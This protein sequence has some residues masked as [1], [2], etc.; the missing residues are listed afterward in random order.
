MTLAAKKLFAPRSE[1]GAPAA[2]RRAPDLALI[3]GSIG[4]KTPAVRDTLGAHL[5][6]A[7]LAT[8]TLIFVANAIATHA[9]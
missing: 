1:Y 4:D 5:G 3:E 6:N 8:Y 2:A 9:I 7:V